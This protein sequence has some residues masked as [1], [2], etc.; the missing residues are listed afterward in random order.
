VCVP[1][2]DLDVGIS[3]RV[4]LEPHEMKVQH[5]R[6]AKEHHTLLGFLQREM[7]I[8]GRN[9]KKKK[10]NTKKM[11]NLKIHTCRTGLPVSHVLQHRTC[12]HRPLT[13]HGHNP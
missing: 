1:V 7:V 12:S 11:L 4:V 5:R 3:D 8:R 6:K 13:P 9:K 2:I 10:K